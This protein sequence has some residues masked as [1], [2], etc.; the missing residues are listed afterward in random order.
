MLTRRQSDYTW[1]RAPPLLARSKSRGP[2][3]EQYWQN[4]QQTL[5]DEVSSAASGFFAPSSTP[6]D[7]RLAMV[8]GGGDPCS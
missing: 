6:P 4:Q 2:V 7:R 1:R 5:H 3:V 8:R